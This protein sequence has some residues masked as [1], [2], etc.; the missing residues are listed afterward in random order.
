MG[1]AARRRQESSARARAG[2]SGRRPTRTGRHGWSSIAGSPDT[3]CWLCAEVSAGCWRRS[4]PGGRRPRRVAAHP[5][6]NGGDRHRGRRRRGRPGPLRV[7]RRPAGQLFSLDPGCRSSGADPRRV[8]ATRAPGARFAAATGW[9]PLPADPVCELRSSRGVPELPRYDDLPAAP[10]GGRSGWGVFGA[11]DNVGLFNLLTPERVLEAAQPDP[12]G[13]PLPARR[14]PRRLL[15]ADRRDPGVPRHHVLHAPGTIG[16]DDVLDNFFPQGSS[17]W[18]SLGHVGY[19]PDVFYNGATEDDV[20][21]GRRNTIEHWARRGIAGRAV[22]ARHGRGPWPTP[23]APTIRARARRSAW[24]T[25]SWPADTPGV[26][27]RPGDILL[28]HTGFAA[29]YREPDSAA[30]R[31]SRSAPGPTTP[32]LAHG[33]DMC[34][35]LWDSARGRGG[36]GHLRRG[37]VPAGSRSGPPGSCTAC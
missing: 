33:E 23:D 22:A 11:D 24:R 36:L 17:Q 14:P 12:Q 29:W 25:S 10:E 4:K 32:G 8:C 13:R 5:D 1:P 6:R 15:A 28:L 34:R 26:E 16:F 9:R 20:A 35:Y 3:L 18:D 2:S 27:F 37:G 7:L 31:G 21:T 30:E 19:A